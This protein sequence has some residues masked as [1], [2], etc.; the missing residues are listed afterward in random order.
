MT[1]GCPRGNG[2]SHC[3]YFLTFYV[4]LNS[5]QSVTTLYPTDF[6]EVSD[7]LHAFK[8]KKYFPILILL[9]FS[10][11]REI[12]NH[13]LFLKWSLSLV[14]KTTHSYFFP[15]CLDPVLLI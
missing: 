6:T 4:L 12:V 3:F 1:R 11:L 10:A 15:T 14:S 2:K 13:S 8:S 5:L 9:D 7:D